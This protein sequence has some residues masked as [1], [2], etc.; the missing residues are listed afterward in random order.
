MGNRKTGAIRV[1]GIVASLDASPR[2]LYQGL[3]QK[4]RPP[5]LPCVPACHPRV[6]V[7]VRKPAPQGSAVRP[8]HKVCLLCYS[9]EPA[10]L[11]PPSPLATEGM[12]REP[13]WEGHVHKGYEVGLSWRAH[14]ARLVGQGS[15]RETAQVDSYG[16]WGR[17]YPPPK[18]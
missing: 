10:W 4:P 1:G 16:R 14:V 18:F 9:S 7:L 11:L 12:R 17:G 8:L 6:T 2:G 13:R 15:R 5:I 3:L